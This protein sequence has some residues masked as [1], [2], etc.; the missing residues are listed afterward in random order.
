MSKWYVV[1]SGLQPGI[2]ST[3]PDCQAQVKGVSGSIF[4]SF[5]SKTEAEAYFKASKAEKPPPKDYD[6][7]LDIYTD[8]SRQRKIGYLGCGAYVKFAEGEFRMSKEC[9]PELLK[10]YSITDTTCSNP[11]AEYMAFAEVLK[12]FKGFQSPHQVKLNFYCD[13]L[14]VKCWT[15]GEW[16]AKVSYIKKIKDCCLKL[17]K[18]MSCDVEVFHVKG[19]SGLAGNDEADS[20]ATDT[21]EYNNFDDLVTLLRQL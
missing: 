12:E 14:G 4:K 21:T 2:Y 13:Y 10:T 1:L 11:T 5:K 18:G 7:E 8:G 9:T 3:W 20:C 15:S 17:M 16:S 6:L 19:H